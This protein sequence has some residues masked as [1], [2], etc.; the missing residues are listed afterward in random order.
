[1]I[2][3]CFAQRQSSSC[4]LDK[5]MTMQLKVSTKIVYSELVIIAVIYTTFIPYIL[6]SMDFKPIHLFHYMTVTMII[7]TPLMIASAFY[8]IDRWE[9]RPIEMLTFYLERRLD[10]PD[11]VMAAARVRT[12]NLPLLHAISVLIRYEIAILL[13]CIYMGTLGGLPLRENIRLW[14]YAAPIVAVYPIFSFFLTE[15]FLHPVRQELAEKTKTAQLDESKVIHINTRTRV[16]SIILATVITPLLALGVL[17]YQHVGTGL[18]AALGSESLAQHAMSHLFVLIFVVTIVAL[19]LA[20]GIGVLLATSIANPLGHM[21]NVIR[22]LEKGNL[23]ARVNLISNDEIGV[24]SE[25]IDKMALQLEKD[26]NDLEDLNRNLEFRVTEKTEHL[27]R[28]YERL[29]ASN[30]NLAIA[31]RELEQANRK[32]HEIDQVKSDFISIVS[33]ELRTPLTSIKAFTELI[34]IK[35]KMSA[36]KRN[37]V[38]TIINNETDRLARLIN[39]ILDLTKIESG[40]LSWHVTKISLEEI[41]QTSVSGIQSLADNKSLAMTTGIKSPLPLIYGD[42]D[43]LIQVITNILSNAIK[44]TPQ[45][46]KIQITAHQ[47]DTPKPQI[48]VSVSDTGIGIPTGDLNLI[49]D[50]FRR[51][52]DVLTNNTEGTGLGLTITRQIVE[53]H[54]GTI[55]AESTPGRGSVFTFTLPLDKS[56]HLIGQQHS[57]IANF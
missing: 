1:L 43:R 28:A 34:L 4:S 31:N 57:A 25:S 53:F 55:W 3:L 21:I 24:L 16:L 12:L 10:P 5:D 29:Q 51:S 17:V 23:H 26:R 56:W 42:R 52:G 38:L 33:H 19:I 47:G 8:F 49:F 32:R 2:L 9:C 20:A 7:L 6:V 27:T 50:K 37:K 40:K 36:E 22:E 45:G 15:R 39:D 48:V 11:G 54:G 30:Q 41:I 46:G 18:S 13:A 35:P 44:F 14:I